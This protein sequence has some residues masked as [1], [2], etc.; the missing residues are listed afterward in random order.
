[1][2]GIDMTEIDIAMILYGT[3]YFFIILAILGSMVAIDNLRESRKNIRAIRHYPQ[4][5]NGRSTIAYM[6]QRRALISLCMYLLLI[7]VGVL[8]LSDGIPATTISAIAFRFAFS[9]YV[10]FLIGSDMTDI[11]DRRQLFRS[12]QPSAYS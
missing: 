1:M 12:H 10:L 11:R 4:F 5:R 7:M 6:M 8:V 2:T 3:E 9:I